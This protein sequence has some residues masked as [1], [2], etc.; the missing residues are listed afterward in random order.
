MPT[1]VF[2]L[3]MGQMRDFR[4]D[5]LGHPSYA[6]DLAPSDFLLFPHLKKFVYVKHFTFNEEVYMVGN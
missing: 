4:Y 3:P 2:F 5:F 6:P 1:K